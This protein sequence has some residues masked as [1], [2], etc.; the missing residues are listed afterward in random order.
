MDDVR[1]LLEPDET[2]Q[3]YLSRI[4]SEKVETGV[5]ILDRYDPIRVTDVIEISGGAGAGKTEILYSVCLSV[6]VSRY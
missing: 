3:Q 2:I 1:A 4:I 5:Q 6:C